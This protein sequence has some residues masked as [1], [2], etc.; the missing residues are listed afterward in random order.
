VAVVR[1]L[2]AK[3]SRAVRIIRENPSYLKA[4]TILRV[5]PVLLDRPRESPRGSSDRISRGNCGD[6]PTTEEI[7]LSPREAFVMG[8][9]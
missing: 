7:A 8:L 1:G 2:K 3:L 6:A 4:L 9:D 5:D